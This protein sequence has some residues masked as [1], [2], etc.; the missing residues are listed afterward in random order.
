MPTLLGAFIVLLA[1][2][3]GPVTA[4][5]ADFITG[6]GWVTTDAI[7]G[8]STAATAASLALGTCSMVRRPARSATPTSRSLRPELISAL[9]GLRP[10]P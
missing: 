2:G 10:P 3:M 1:M 5:R 6:Y 4:A 7:A 8:S 9:L